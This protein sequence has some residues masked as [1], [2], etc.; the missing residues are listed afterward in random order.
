MKKIS[1]VVP[2]ND[3]GIPTVERYTE[4]L[5]RPF[6][7]DRYYCRS[8]RSKLPLKL[9]SVS[10]WVGLTPFPVGFRKQ[11]YRDP[12]GYWDGFVRSDEVAR[13]SLLDESELLHSRYTL[14]EGSY[15]TNSCVL[16]RMASKSTGN[17]SVN[18]LLLHSFNRYDK[19]GFPDIKFDIKKKWLKAV[20]VNPDACPGL[21]TQRRVASNKKDSYPVALRVA[22]ELW[23]KIV[24]SRKPIQDYSLWGIGGRSR[25]MDMSKGESPRSRLILM[26]E[27]SASLIGGL[28]STMF[29]LAYKRTD[30]RDT[31]C[32]MGQEVTNG[33][34]KRLR[35]FARDGQYVLELDWEE[36]DS[37]LTENALVSAFCLIRTCFPRSKKIDKLFLFVMSGTIHKHIPLRGRFIYRI[38]KGLPSGSPLTSILGTVTNW[39]LLN[40]TLMTSNLFGIEGTDDFGLAC[41]G[42]DTLIR[43]NNLD[44][45]RHEDAETFCGTF[46][47]KVNLTVKPDDLNFCIWNDGGG[48]EDAEYS[49]SLLKTSIWNGIPGRRVSDLVKSISCPERNVNSYLDIFNILQGY[50]TLPIYTPKA[51]ALLCAFS[52]WLGKY[53]KGQLGVTDEQFS[54]DVNKEDLYYNTS[55][56]LLRT[57][58]DLELAELDPWYLA[59]LKLSGGIPIRRSARV[60]QLFYSLHPT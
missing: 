51:R 56:S 28:I 2:K 10:R 9:N 35:D 4:Y 7:H 25:R 36:F 44:K 19:F 8:D 46:K 21:Y 57:K 50:T 41:A 54:F 13:T 5:D 23:D 12:L 53:V 48:I 24:L 14:I 49:P 38:S 34:W 40:Y 15:D 58:P 1:K 6:R 52:E 16:E 27:F 37:N 59:K 55:Y 18:D 47:D 42:D 30:K 32:F 43:F 17:P 3:G 26:P 60:M 33:S 20:S 22:Y 29:N 45:F 31:E 11:K 39:I